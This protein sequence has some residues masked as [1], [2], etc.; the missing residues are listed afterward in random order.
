VFRLLLVLL[1]FST[2]SLNKADG[3]T[4]P[5]P[6]NTRS[7]AGINEGT[8]VSNEDI[9]I[10]VMQGK[11]I[12]PAKGKP[13]V[14]DLGLSYMLQIVQNKNKPQTAIEFIAK[15]NREGLIPVLRLCF[16]DSNTC[17]LKS[18]ADIYLFYE[19]VAQGLAGTNY[20]FVAALGPNEPGSGEAEAFGVAHGDYATLVNWANTAAAYLQRYRVK[21]GGNIYLAPAIFNGTNSVPGSDDVRGYLYS[22]PTINAD[23]FDY[24]LTNLYNDGGKTAKY[25]YKEEGR[26][27][28]KYVKAHPHLKTII[29]ENGF[30]EFYGNPTDLELFETGYVK[31]CNDPT[32]SGILFFRPLAS[33]KLPPNYPAFAP[34]QYPAIKPKTLQKIIQSCTAPSPL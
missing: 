32:I 19:K 16:G 29:T 13:Y 14:P 7:K 18:A 33:E 8:L 6:K 2:I 22:Q 25:F 28:R 4:L 24:I 10:K 23:N 12:N 15:A 11:V 21:N 27:M 34:R 26:S 1:V 20:F 9:I 31:L 17:T 5:L 3:D 30:K